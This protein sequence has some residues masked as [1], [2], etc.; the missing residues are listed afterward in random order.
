M[1]ASDVIPNVYSF[2][3]A[4]SACGKA[5]QWE[6]ATSL[7]DDMF[8]TNVTPDVYSFSAAIQACAAGRQPAVALRIFEA[9]DSAVE[10]N[11]VTTNAVLDAI[12]AFD[13]TRAR[14]LWRRG[15]EQGLYPVVERAEGRMP[16][17]DLHDHSEGAA[18][19]AV[20]WWLEERVPALMPPAD[21]LVIITGYGKSREAHQTTDVRGRVIQVVQ[22]MGMLALQAAGNPGR[23]EIS[24]DNHADDHWNGCQ[25]LFL[26]TVRLWSFSPFLRGTSLP[27]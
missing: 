16:M 14:E 9:A 1:R 6:R 21:K 19:T 24:R 11:R 2:N 8:A 17:L 26:H 25:S 5:G 27:P 4:I 23:L 18:E 10:L 22:E 15:I 7:L 12:C 13:P 20:R 3:A